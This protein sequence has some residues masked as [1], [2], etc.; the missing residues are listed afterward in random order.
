MELNCHLNKL[1]QLRKIDFL[2]IYKGIG[3]PQ[4]THS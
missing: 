4:K 1:V 2:L 3:A